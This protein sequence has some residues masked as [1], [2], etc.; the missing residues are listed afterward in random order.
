MSKIYGG[1]GSLEPGSYEIQEG[2][3]IE[4]RSF[5]TVGQ[6]AEF[7]DVEIDP[8][9]EILVNNR[10]ATMD[11]LIYAN[12]SIDWTVLSF[13]AAPVA[14]KENTS[15]ASSILD[16]L[17]YG[18]KYGFGA[19]AEDS[20][21][22]DAKETTNEV[23]QVEA[24]ASDMPLGYEAEQ[25]KS[26]TVS[27]SGMAEEVIPDEME[28]TEQAGIHVTVNQEPVFLSGKS[29]YILWTSLM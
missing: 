1:N 17:K 14:P 28:G 16:Q 8:D 26:E 23:N 2:D 11:S 10:S 7:M 15:K 27:G 21:A 13:G 9:R 3:A 6:L 24:E 12:F 22:E 20:A 4:T 19:K 25:E 29:N 18:S 5:Y